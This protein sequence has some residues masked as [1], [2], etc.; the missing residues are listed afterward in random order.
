MADPKIL[1]VEDEPDI[2]NLLHFHMQSQ[3]YESHTAR[4]GESGLQLY[5]D[6]R[7]DLVILDIMLPGQSGLEVCK[8]IRSS[9]GGQEVGVLLLTA[10]GEEQ[11]RVQ[12]L[13]TGADDYVVKPFSP[14][15]LLL[16]VQAIL[17][18]V[19]KAGNREDNVWQSQGLRV[20]FDSLRVFVD[21]QEV[22]LTATEFNML[23]VLIRAAGRVLTREQLLDQVWGYEFVGYARTVDTHMHR[24]R[25]KLGSYSDLLQTVR[26]FGYR[27][28]KKN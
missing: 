22:E 27:L 12:G 5:Q 28:Q 10:K 8:Q 18:R 11:D 4:D 2:L 26:G 24:L 21:G 15:E 16:R 3:D 23:R 7:P 17:R 6:L 1:I 25:H 14:R 13:E 20:E 19:G 9:P